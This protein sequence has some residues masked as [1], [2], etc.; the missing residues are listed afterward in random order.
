MWALFSK[1]HFERE[2][3]FVHM[4]A[5]Y[6]WTLETGKQSL[7]SQVER[8]FINWKINK[9]VKHNFRKVWKGVNFPDLNVH[10]V[11]L[12]CS[13]H[14]NISD[15]PYSIFRVYRSGAVLSLQ[16]AYSEKTNSLVYWIPIL[17]ISQVSPED[18][19]WL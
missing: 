11:F 14:Y 5:S 6:T 13:L 3:T 1:H 2:I 16:N 10:F 17:N 18:D 15:G 8:L 9:Q 7:Q 19:K 4:H 12:P